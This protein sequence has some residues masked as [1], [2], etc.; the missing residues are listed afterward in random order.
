M[1]PHTA[2]PPHDATRSTPVRPCGAR[3]G[4]RGRP[5]LAVRDRR[6]AVHR[7]CRRPH[8][9]G[10]I[11]LHV[12]TGWPRRPRCGCG[13]SP[14]GRGGRR[15]WPPRSSRLH[16]P[17]V[18][19]RDPGPDRARARRDGTGRRVGLAH[20]LVLP[21]GPLSS[22]DTPGDA[23]H[24]IRPGRPSEPDRGGPSDSARAI[25]VTPIPSKGPGPAVP[26][27]PGGVRTPASGRSPPQATRREAARCSWRPGRPSDSSTSPP[28][29]TGVAEIRGRVRTHVDETVRHD[30]APS[31]CTRCAV[32]TSSPGS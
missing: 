9:V 20:R 7:W 31:T 2:T 17:G 22:T 8:G 25:R 29:R 1:S 15:S 12:V 4:V 6:G 26:S 18:V 30:A 16:L 32:R 19:R 11:V 23:G 14:A 21:P 27:A 3:D 28:T 10:A 13:W 24:P 5:G